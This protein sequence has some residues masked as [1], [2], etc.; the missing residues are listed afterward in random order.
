MEVDAHVCYLGIYGFQAVENEECK[1]C[2]EERKKSKRVFS[3]EIETSQCQNSLEN[4]RI[5]KNLVL[6]IIVCCRMHATFTSGTIQASQVHTRQMV[7]SSSP[8]CTFNSR[9]F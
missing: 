5:V 8:L 3:V 2:F 1:G 4:D 6:W 9:Q 7:C